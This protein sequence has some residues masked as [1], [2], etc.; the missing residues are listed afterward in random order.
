[1]SDPVN[2]H[3]V[4]SLEWRQ[5]WKRDNVLSRYFGFLDRPE[6]MACNRCGAFVAPDLGLLHADWHDES[7][8]AP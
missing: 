4:G 3:P 2:P 1:M 6:G 8:V 5:W 7:E